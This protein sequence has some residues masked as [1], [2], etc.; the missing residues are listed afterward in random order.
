[1]SVWDRVANPVP[2]SINTW[3]RLAVWAA[4]VA[5]NLAQA[6]T[7]QTVQGEPEQPVASVSVVRL[8]DGR[9][10]FA[11]LN[12]I[13]VDEAELNSPTEKTWMAAMDMSTAQPHV[14]LLS[15]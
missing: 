1:M 11:T 15:N 8:A 7:V 4:Q 9:S 5:S 6:Q 12:Y 13:R 2:S 10:Y 3:E 14:N